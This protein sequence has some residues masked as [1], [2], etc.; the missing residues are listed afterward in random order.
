MTLS[1]LAERATSLHGKLAKCHPALERGL[2][3]C[4]ECGRVEKVE[5]AHCLRHGWPKCCGATMTI[6]VRARASQEHSE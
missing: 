4:R 3:E 5:S 6:D 1:E 2:V